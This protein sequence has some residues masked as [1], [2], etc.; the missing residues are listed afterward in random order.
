MSR[1]LCAHFKTFYSKNK[2]CTKP[3]KPANAEV[4]LLRWVEMSGSVNIEKSYKAVYRENG[5]E[6]EFLDMNGR[7]LLSPFTL[8]DNP[9]IE[10]R[11]YFDKWNPVFNQVDPSDI[12]TWEQL[13]R[14]VGSVK[15]FTASLNNKRKEGQTTVN[16][17]PCEKS[18]YS[19]AG[20]EYF[21]IP[22]REGE[23]MVTVRGQST[24]D[25][26]KDGDWSTYGKDV[27]A[28][29]EMPPPYKEG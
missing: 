19:I 9:E 17:H 29:A 13:R 25:V 16:W 22:K 11:I 15:D 26:F 4:V 27:A 10:Y 1:G 20:I 28:W 14:R 7:L 24:T 5:D 18:C 2:R 21:D 6:W 8:D 23:Y 12:P 3:K